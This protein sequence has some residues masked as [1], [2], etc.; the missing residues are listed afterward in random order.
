M[1]TV[2]ARALVK[3]DMPGE[4]PRYQV[5]RQAPRRRLFWAAIGCGW[6]LSLAVA[7][8]VAGV[9]GTPALAVPSMGA[10]ALRSELD[11]AV[12]EVERL[13]QQHVV[14]ERSDQVSRA[15]NR[16]IQQELAEREEEIARLK[17]DLAFYERIANGDAP[18]KGLNVH[19][20]EFSPEVAGS[21]RYDIV[22]TQDIERTSPSKGQ[23]RFTIEGVQDGRLA[24]LDW[25]TLHQREQAPAQSFA[26]RYFQR[27]Q[28]NVM[29]P[30]GFTPQRVRV[31]LR[32]PD[33]SLEQA[34]AWVQPES[35]GD[36]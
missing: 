7:W 1:G 13:R 2:G 5:V 12:A 3:I 23:L 21:W 18:R 34:L 20:A 26:F 19:S 11:S 30:D 27:L 16:T 31:S 15:A 28:G 6:L 14:L 9:L 24:T 33:A 36:A 4:I 8:S 17:A 22:L 35:R 10:A 32:G 25:N 29:L